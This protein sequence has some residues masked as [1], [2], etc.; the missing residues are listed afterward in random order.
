MEKYDL[1]ND[2]PTQ[3]EW[4]EDATKEE[5]QAFIY[6]LCC[7]DTETG[8]GKRVF[9]L[10]AARKYTLEELY[11]IQSFMIM[12]DSVDILNAG[13]AA[14]SFSNILKA[15]KELLPPPTKEEKAEVERKLLE[16]KKSHPEL[17]GV[18]EDGN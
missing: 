14:I 3:K 12:S 13:K 18:V 10:R 6:G 2:F 4:L 11:C 1:N 9:T 5:Q 15:E 17:F 7:Y 8:E 16:F